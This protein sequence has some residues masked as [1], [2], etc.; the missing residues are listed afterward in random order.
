[1]P[2]SETLQFLAP[3]HAPSHRALRTVISQAG[4]SEQDVRTLLW[5]LNAHPKLFA[6]RRVI[7]MRIQWN[8]SDPFKAR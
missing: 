4:H 6:F 5:R 7:L 1:M 3:Q 2:K 8:S